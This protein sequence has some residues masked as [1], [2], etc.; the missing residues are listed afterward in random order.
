M[1]NDGV[2]I[3]STEFCSSEIYLKVSALYGS[4][5]A[6]YFGGETVPDTGTASF[7]YSIDN[8]VFKSIGNIM[9]MQ[10]YLSVF[11]GN[12]YCLFNYPEIEYGGYVDFDWFRTGPASKGER[13]EVD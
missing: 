8:K 6:M 3:D 12:K 4:G 2:E 13:L 10:F 1:V 9:Q 5:G 11:T 7:S